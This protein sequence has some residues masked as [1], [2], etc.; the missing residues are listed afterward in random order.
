MG[1]V[2]VPH[3]EGTTEEYVYPDGT[4]FD[5]TKCCKPDNTVTT[6]EVKIRTLNGLSPERVKVQ[7]GQK[8]EVVEIKATHRKVVVANSK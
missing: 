1:F 8:W 2:E 7:L 6:F 4:P 5:T 3:K